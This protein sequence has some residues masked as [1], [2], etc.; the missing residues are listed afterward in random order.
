MKKQSLT[1]ILS[2]LL[3]LT[4][5]I[6]P[7]VS[8]FWYSD[9]FALDNSKINEKNSEL[10]K[11]TTTQYGVYTIKEHAWYDV[12]KIW[13]E[14]KIKEV[15][16]KDNSDICS[17]DC[18]AIKE[19]TNLKPAPL[20]EDV[21]FLRDFGDGKWISWDGFTNWKV[22]VEEDVEQFETICK[23][24]KEIIDE[25]NG[26]SYFEQDCSLVSTGFVKQW[27]NLDFKKEYEGTYKVKLEGG[28]KESTILDW[29]VKINGYWTEE[30]AVWGNISDGDDAEVIL[31]TPTDGSTALSNPVNF[32][33]FFNIT[34]GAYG[35]NMSHCSNI[36]G[37]WECGDSVDL[38]GGVSKYRETHG[39]SLSTTTASQTFK[40]GSKIRTGSQTIYLENVSVD[41]SDGTNKIYIRTTAGGADIATATRSAG[42]IYIF[43]TPVELSA[44][45]NYYIL[46]DKQGSSYQTEYAYTTYPKVNTLYN[47]TAGVTDGSDRSDWIGA[48]TYLGTSTFIPQTNYTNTWSKTISAGSTLWNVQACDSDGDCGFSVANYTVSVDEGAPTIEINAGNG[49][50]NYGSLTQNHTINFT[51]TDDNLDECWFNYNGTNSSN[52]GCSTGV[53]ESINFTLVED[54]YTITIYAND[55]VGN[56]NSTT[57]SWSYRI[58]ENS[59]TYSAN[60]IGGS[61]ESFYLNITLNEAVE[62]SSA[63]LVYN[64]T[65]ETASITSSGDNRILGVTGFEIPGVSVETNNAFYWHL[66]LSDSIGINSTSYIQTVSTIALDNCDSYTNQLF[67]LSLLDEE[68]LTPINGTIE[69]YYEVLNVPNHDTI[70]NYTGNFKDI[71]NTLVCSEVNLSGQNLLYSTEIRYYA[72]DYATE[73]YHIQRASL[74]DPVTLSLYDLALNDSTEFKLTYK[75]S[76]VLKVPLAIIQLQRKYISENI[77][78]TVEAPLT[79]DDGTTIVHIDLDTNKYRAV[80]VKN[81]VILDV[82]ENIVFHCKNELSGICEHDLFADIDS[83]NSISIENLEDFAYAISDSNETISITFSIPSGEPSN[84]NIELSQLDQFGNE[85]LCN[86]TVY[87]SSGTVECDYSTTIGN[88]YLTLKLSKDGVVKGIKSYV[89]PEA[90]AVDFLGN[91]FFIVFIFMLSIIG[92]AFTSPEW[93]IINSVITLLLA[94]SLWLLNGLNFV[95]GLG[96]LMWLV[97]ASGILIMKL[98]KQED[99]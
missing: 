56:M 22:L 89:I 68:L 60:T 76:N 20:I 71:S 72:D 30:W 43:S 16:L 59:Q 69:L 45:T 42:N 92:M 21:R 74:D 93:I 57:Y 24:G 63:T 40:I 28:K 1:A 44:N 51:V 32:T 48:I 55:S 73:L 11:E 18:F 65:T 99:K 64:T 50:Q 33:A 27:N 98:S 66:E 19:I 26:T 41:A 86:K 81:G 7:S 97:V 85:T 87:S 47:W 35:V 12:L 29:Q 4:L 90:G 54:L 62:I 25:K 13:T 88:S 8:A 70:Q 14:E 23:D 95:M 6:A 5:L 2:L 58:F 10:G 38:T 49:T 77:Y 82:F 9:D 84:I 91:N 37:S 94:G 46:V 31:I 3:V 53:L 83:H 36:T 79:S 78:R 39:V 34:G 15:E 80:V 61:I 96:S 52:L 67:N 75:N 17:N